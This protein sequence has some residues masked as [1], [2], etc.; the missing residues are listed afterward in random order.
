MG[1]TGHKHNNLGNVPD[2]IGLI[3][4][5]ARWYLPGLGRF[6]SA[7]TLVPNPSNPQSYNRYSY[8]NN[9][10]LLYTD[11]TGHDP[12]PLCQTIPESCG[13]TRPDLEQLSQEFESFELTEETKSFFGTNLTPDEYE[14]V[15]LHWVRARKIQQIVN[16]SFAVSGALFWQLDDD[17]NL[18]NDI[19][20]AFRHSYWS[21]LM[22]RE[23]GSEFAEEFTTAHETGTREDARREIFMDMH[24][25]SVGIQIGQ[26]FQ[27]TDA[28]LIVEVFNALQDGSLVVY[29]MQQ[30]KYFYSDAY[31]GCEILNSLT[32]TVKD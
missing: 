22:T 29:N 7:D 20:D 6:I 27:G 18:H 8:T 11:P 24:N 19:G 14:L 26:T 23:F 12:A 4:M 15:S 5:N 13:E 25:N 16:D 17:Q 2:D 3:Y 1:Y 31:P 30:D 9:N 10:P 21:A 28:E 32:V